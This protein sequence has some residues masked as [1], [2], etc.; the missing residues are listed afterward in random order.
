MQKPLREMKSIAACKGSRSVCASTTAPLTWAW[1]T[2]EGSSTF[3]GH[4]CA[5]RVSIEKDRQGKTRR[6]N[7][8]G[9][10]RM[11]RLAG[12]KKEGQKDR[13]G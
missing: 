6:I 1:A 3:R 8:G 7:D 9:E 2:W 12:K 10:G 4:C 5:S 13:T 11:A